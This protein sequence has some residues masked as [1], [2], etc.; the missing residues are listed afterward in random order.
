MLK[1]L[2]TVQSKRVYLIK[3][4]KIKLQ[5]LFNKN[6]TNNF[7]DTIHSIRKLLIQ[8]LVISSGFA[9]SYILIF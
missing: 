6:R 5:I 8:K 9:I 2:L 1:Y 7:P 4:L 3:I